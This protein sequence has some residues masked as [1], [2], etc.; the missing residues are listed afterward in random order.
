MYSFRIRY[1]DENYGGD[2]G[3]SNGDDSN[4]IKSGTDGR[5]VSVVQISE[6]EAHPDDSISDVK[7]LLQDSYGDAWGL[8][9]RRLDRDRI[10]I[11]WELVQQRVDVGG[12]GEESRSLEVMSYHLFLHSYGVVSGGVIHAVVRRHEGEDGGG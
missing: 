5:E 9:D 11:G 1:D 4:E 6:L 3:G 7:R 10:A 8:M 2:G 12:G